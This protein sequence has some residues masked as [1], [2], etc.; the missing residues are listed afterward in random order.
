MDS[1]RE[2]SIRQLI[3]NGKSRPALDHAKDLFKQ[4]RSPQA[5]ALLLDCYEARVACLIA[6][7]MP[8]EALALV[9]L[10]KERHPVAGARF[11][12]IEWRAAIEQ[13]NY[14]FLKPLADAECEPALKERLHGLVKQDILTP[15]ALAACDEEVWAILLRSS[16]RLFL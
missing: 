10:V 7:H 15:G 3:A 16:E 4:E 9:S 5:E 13:G 2:N 8:V 12:E 11:E 1:A 14:D 6:T